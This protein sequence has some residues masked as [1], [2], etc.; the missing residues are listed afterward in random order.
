MFSSA[1][2]PH[3]HYRT[4]L[5]DST[6]VLIWLIEPYTLKTSPM[7]IQRLRKR[8]HWRRRLSVGDLDQNLRS[9]V[10]PRVP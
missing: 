10:E 5:I 4:P 8:G 1:L 9:Y 7:R 3:I 6:V 2:L